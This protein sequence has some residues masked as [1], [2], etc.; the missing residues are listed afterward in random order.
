VPAKAKKEFEEACDLVASQYA[1]A[2]EHLLKATELYPKYA[3]AWMLLGQ[4]QIEQSKRAE[5][6]ESCQH[7]LDS[8]S[9]YLSPYICLA[10]LAVM[11]QKWDVVSDFT[12]R[13]LERHPVKAPG[14][15]YYNALAHYHRHEMAAAE[16]S[17][18][19]AVQESGHD[20]V[21]EVH[22]LFARIYE[23]KKDRASEAA[24]LRQYLKLAPHAADAALVKTILR[25]I[26]E[27]AT[28]SSA[29]LTPKADLESK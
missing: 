25:Q 22:Y 12:N 26:D 1:K 23:A 6:G 17:A 27:Q 18:T 20:Q 24:E 9:E 10:M 21:P 8:D 14:A 28:G 7:A 2:E 5:A 19:R 4:L 16:K 3:E 15:H 13:V 11:E 29:A